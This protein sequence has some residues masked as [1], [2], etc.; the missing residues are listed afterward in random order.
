ML[1][2]ELGLSA[3]CNQ[4][5]VRRD[6]LLDCVESAVHDLLEASLFACG[7]LLGRLG[8]PQYA[9]DAPRVYQVGYRP[10]PAGRFEEL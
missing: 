6:A 9:R 2:P 3:Y 5:L 10:F 4:D 8:S 1:F 7:L